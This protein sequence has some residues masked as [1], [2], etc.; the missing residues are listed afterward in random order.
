MKTEI[1]KTESELNIAARL[2]EQGALVAVPTETVYGL[3]GNGLD[4][5]AV[6]RIYEVKGRPS[7]KPLSLMIPGPEAMGQYCLSLPD[8]A[9]YLAEKFWPGPL[10]IVLRARDNIPSIVL[11]GGDTVGLRCPR[12]TL[13]LRLLELTGLPFAAPSANRSGEESPKTAEQVEKYFDGKIEGIVDGGPCG[14]G[15]ESTIIDMSG[16]TYRILRQ[17][18]LP[19]ADIKAALAEQLKIIGITGGSGSGKT[20]ALEVLESMGALILDCDSIY[21]QLLEKD[22]EMLS[23]IA[24]SFPGTVC[25]GQLDRKALGAV[26]FNDEAALARLNGI[27]HRCVDRELSRRLE[28]FAM[29]GGRLAAIDA[30]ELFAGNQARRCFKTV[31]VLAD[32]EIRTE[33]I[34][35]RDGISREYARMRIQAQRP[36]AYFEKLCDH[37]LF[38]DAG[39][40]EFEEKCRILFKEILSN[41]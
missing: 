10:T 33:R 15:L 39:R 1:F 20:T 32:P 23:E 41:E 9:K 14:L 6:E 38:N 8:S 11:A 26:V 37:I 4:T 24:E 36:D 5:A 28:D 16:N 35:K 27:T 30:I 19:A 21:H 40:D 22:K 25:A 12:H 31:A 13:T 34:M 7:V 17:G 3:A 2:I 29:E 18:A